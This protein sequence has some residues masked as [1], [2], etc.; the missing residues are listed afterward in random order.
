MNVVRRVRN[1]SP[2]PATLLGV[3][4]AKVT[5]KGEV[6][7]HTNVNKFLRII[8]ICVIYFILDCQQS[9]LQ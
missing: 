7:C 6:S 1:V 3:Q 8:R 9:V 2:E 5:A 4:G